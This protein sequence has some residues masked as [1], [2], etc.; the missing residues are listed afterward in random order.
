MYYSYVMFLNT[1]I[2]VVVAIE[3]QVGFSPDFYKSF[4][5]LCRQ[6]YYIV[7]DGLGCFILVQFWRF[8]GFA[9]FRFSRRTSKFSFRSHERGFGK[10]E[11]NWIHCSQIQ[12]RLEW[13]GKGTVHKLFEGEE[14]HCICS[15]IS[16][17]WT[18]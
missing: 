9:S 5:V 18:T 8:W 11:K 13:N 10:L 2:L 17:D 15:S 1:L 4:A 6:F 14:V 3:P 16:I 7:Y 12:K